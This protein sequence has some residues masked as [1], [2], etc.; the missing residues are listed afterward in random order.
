MLVS[1]LIERKRDGGELSDSEWS[2][3]LHRYQRGRV[4][5]YQMAA[6]AMAIYFEGLTGEELSSVTRIMLDSG[7]RLDFGDWSTPRVD[8]H[9]TGGVGD[10]T[11][12]LLAP[13]LAACGAA[14]PMISGRGLG[15]TGG[16]LD[17]LEA[18]PG[19]TT[20]LS[21]EQAEEQVR[22]IGC[23]MLGQTDDIAPIDRKLYALRDVTG[24][25]ESIPLIAASIMSKKLAEDLDSLVLDVKLGSGSFMPDTE[26]AVELARTMI[27]LGDSHGC[28]TVAYLTAMDRPLGRACGNALEIEEC[29]MALAGEGPPDLMEVTLA[30]GSEMLVTSGLAGDAAAAR[31][32]LDDAIATGA[33]REKLGQLIERQGGSP[34]LVDDPAGLPQAETVEVY[35][36]PKSGVVSQ[37]DPR[38]IGRAII[39]L[40]GGRA[41]IDDQV[42]PAVGFVISAKPG[43]VVTAGEPLA[44]VFAR[45]DDDA[46]AGLAALDQAITITEEAPDLP[47]PLVSCRITRDG[48]EPYQEPA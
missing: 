38:S 44:S 28:R 12:L 17:K 7:R 3:L 27:E 47:L 29:L 32:R 9:S 30:L 8:K 43:D 41:R 25:I 4:P 5:E 2:E 6:L 39:E 22:A 23:A 42:D 10:K 34:A 31:S 19:F 26:Q 21:L 40:G 48:V 11:S 24:T 15:H 37:V 36:A 45:S 16:T 35:Q 33:A 14:V 18:I 46:A 20:A 1:S 13:L